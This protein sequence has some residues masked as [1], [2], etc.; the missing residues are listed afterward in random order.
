M[1]SKIAICIARLRD[2]I[3]LEVRALHNRTPVRMEEAKKGIVDSYRSADEVPEMQP[4]EKYADLI[5]DPAVDLVMVN[6]PQY[7]HRD[8]TIAALRSGKKVYLDKPLAHTL[9]DALAIY[10]EQDRSGN[11]VIM[12]F[13]AVLRVPGSRPGSS[14][15]RG[16]S[17]LYG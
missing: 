17:V 6:T 1:R 12:S 16:S 11:Q 13:T 2:R 9:E 3:D 8:P 10:R 7:A 4:Y 15:S 5:A 14:S